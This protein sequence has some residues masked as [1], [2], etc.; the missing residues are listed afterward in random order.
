MQYFYGRCR[1]G[2]HAPVTLPKKLAI[3][4]KVSSSCASLIQLGSMQH[5]D[6]LSKVGW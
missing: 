4:K 3:K 2:G 1:Q 6:N 5:L